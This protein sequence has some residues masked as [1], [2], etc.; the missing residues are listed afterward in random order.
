MK[1]NLLTPLVAEVYMWCACL[2]AHSC[3]NIQPCVHEAEG[4]LCKQQATEQR[5]RLHALR[6]SCAAWMHAARVLLCALPPLYKNDVL[7]HVI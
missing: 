6:Q 1:N 3:A 4:T 7:R 2:H 5:Y